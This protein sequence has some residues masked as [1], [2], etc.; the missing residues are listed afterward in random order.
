MPPRRIHSR[1][2]WRTPLFHTCATWR[3]P[4]GLPI[5]RFCI[6]TLRGLP[7]TGQIALALLF[8]IGVTALVIAGRRQR[9]LLVGW[10]WFLGTL[11]PMIGLV[12]VGRQAMADRYAY[13]SFIGLFIM[14][15]WGL[16]DWSEQW[17]I[18]SAWAAAASLAVLLALAVVTHRQIGYWSDSYALWTHALQVTGPNK[19]A[20]ENLGVLL[21][22]DK[23]LDE[24]LPHLQEAVV[25]DP[26]SPLYNMNLAI[27][28]Q[29]QGK[30][31][32]AIEH[33]K[34]L[35][36]LTQN[37][38]PHYVKWRNDAFTNMS[39]AYRDLENPAYSSEN[40]KAAP[41]SIAP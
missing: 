3:R 11:V 29:R 26:L 37:D 10:L 39:F 33:Y 12:Q 34:A 1:F 13:L 2:E 15:C 16:A 32:Q 28:E 17:Q 9:Y 8:L 19:G 4:F 36:S 21:M 5:S 30:L 14:I 35:I 27:C 7:P 41:E 6:L 31:R 25:L 24:A 20:E 22:N 18:S 23:R 38:I 40:Q